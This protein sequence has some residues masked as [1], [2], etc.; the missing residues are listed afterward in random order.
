MND[1]K[2]LQS[3][4]DVGGEITIPS[5]NPATGD[6]FYIITE[7]LVLRSGDHV[8][9]DGCILQLADGVYSNIFI[10][11]GAWDENPA[12]VTDISITAINGGRLDGG[13]PNGLT[14]K[15]EKKDG[16]PP[17]LRNSFILFNNVSNFKLTSLKLTELRYWAI[18]LYYCSDG[19]I[20][21]IE[22]KAS[23]NVPN[24]DGIDL[25]RGCHDIV[26]N[27]ITGSTGDDTVALTGLLTENP[28]H[29]YLKDK[30]Q[31]IYNV[32]ITNI[33]AEV[34]GGHSIVRLLCHDGIKMYSI[35]VSNVY[36]RL[37]DTRLTRNQ[38]AIRIGDVNYWHIKPAEA[39]DMYDITV[40][41]VTT[42]AVIPVK[43]YEK[44]AGEEYVKVSN[45]NVVK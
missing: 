12:E 38:G 11:E 45:I 16:R 1:S 9:I 43:I 36:D 15:T 30:S 17:V 21:D 8:I 40:S 19:V 29:F 42:N 4:I 44:I 35:K 14:E 41:D 23:N 13:K 37:I 5:I 3:L 32:T 28:T 25:R 6:N 27:N 22:F 31:D 39:G 34:T 24:Q 20:E 26:I 10:S 18:T 7:A 33:S 2:Y